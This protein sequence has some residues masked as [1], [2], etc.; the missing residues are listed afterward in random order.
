VGAALTS[1]AGNSRLSA[2]RP[3]RWSACVRWHPTAVLIEDSKSGTAIISDL[4]LTGIPL[5]PISPAGSDNEANARG[6]PRCPSP[7]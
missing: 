5:L 1:L 6:F 4:H 3:A 7:A 2:A